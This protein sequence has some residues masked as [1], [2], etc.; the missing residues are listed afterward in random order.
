MINKKNKLTDLSVI[1]EV[2]SL[3]ELSTFD[4]L[5]RNHSYVL[6]E[7]RREISDEAVQ[8]MYLLLDKYFKKHQGV[9]INGGLVSVTLR[10][11]IKDSY[12]YSKRNILVGLPTDVRQDQTKGEE[13]YSEAESILTR[14]F[15]LSDKDRTELL[16]YT[17]NTCT[18]IYKM[19][20]NELKYDTIRLERREF[21]N[22]LKEK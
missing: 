22:K 10:N 21:I 16:K 3:Q 5:I 1:K 4:V 7:K 14:V 11:L 12:K 19:K 9:T 20:D 17:Y 6:S 18:D 15:D 8:E 13:A 2:G